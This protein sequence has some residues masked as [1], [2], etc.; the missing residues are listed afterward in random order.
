MVRISSSA[1]AILVVPIPLMVSFPS[2][3]S[4]PPN[5]RLQPAWPVK[6]VFSLLISRN[7]FD[8][9]IALPSICVNNHLVPEASDF[10]PNAAKAVNITNID[11]T[12]KR[13]ADLYILL[14]IPNLTFPPKL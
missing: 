6:R 11:A 4:I 10:C 9:E 8:A 2:K 14:I 7:A 13:S 1:H 12:A 3:D 5:I